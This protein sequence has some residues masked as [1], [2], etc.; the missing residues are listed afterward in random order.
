MR[1]CAGARRCSMRSRV[2]LSCLVVACASLR[3]ALPG[4]DMGAFA[5]LLSRGD[6][7]AFIA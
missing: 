3:Y 2:A 6:I 1:A 7:P 4:G 5:V